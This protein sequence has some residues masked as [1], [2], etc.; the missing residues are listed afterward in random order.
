MGLPSHTIKRSQSRLLGDPGGL[1]DDLARRAEL[2]D[3]CTKEEDQILGGRLAMPHEGGEPSMFGAGKDAPSLFP[4]RRQARPR[5]GK[6]MDPDHI[7]I[8][9]D[10]ETLRA[11]VHPSRPQT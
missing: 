4:Q 2:T 1:S 8:E 5:G 11:L 6:E 10:G 9:R 7:L 3:L